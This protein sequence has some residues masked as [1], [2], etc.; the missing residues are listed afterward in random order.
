MRS[1]YEYDYLRPLPLI[2]FSPP[3]RND[4]VGFCG[5][6]AIGRVGGVEGAERDRIDG[7]RR[8]LAEESP[9][10]DLLHPA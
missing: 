4:L 2:Y 9:R 1:V 5:A 8:F 10:F 3:E 7:V 6:A